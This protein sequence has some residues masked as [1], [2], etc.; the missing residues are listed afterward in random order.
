MVTQVYMRGER[1]VARR[2]NSSREEV[3]PYGPRPLAAVLANKVDKILQHT[4]T[5]NELDYRVK[6]R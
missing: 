3:E 5:P 4:R 6:C 2:R 1:A